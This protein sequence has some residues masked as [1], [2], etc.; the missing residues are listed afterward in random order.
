MGA[1]VDIVDHGAQHVEALCMNTGA[2]RASKQTLGAVT[3]ESLGLVSASFELEAGLTGTVGTTSSHGDLESE[4]LA[5]I[6]ASRGPVGEINIRDPQGLEPSLSA[7]HDQLSFKDTPSECLYPFFSC[8][9]SLGTIGSKW[10]FK[11]NTIPSARM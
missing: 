3:G 9:S 7:K 2:Q 8:R 11:W 6:A 5:R 1:D 4:L 10:G